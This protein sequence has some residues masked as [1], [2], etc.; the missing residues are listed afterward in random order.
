MKRALLTIPILELN[1]RIVTFSLRMDIL[2]DGLVKNLP[3]L[4]LKSVSVHEHSM[5]IT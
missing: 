4:I 5:D 1:K 3:K 2:S